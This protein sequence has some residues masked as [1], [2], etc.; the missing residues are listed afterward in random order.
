MSLIIKLPILG[1]ASIV[2]TACSLEKYESEP[3]L[4]TTEMGLVT[5]QL[6]TKDRVLF[7]KAIDIP[8]GMA[9]EVANNLCRTEGERSL[10][11]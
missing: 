2:L 1:A 7:D 5:C 4:L 8:E 11:E 10:S 6:Y 9:V 3:V